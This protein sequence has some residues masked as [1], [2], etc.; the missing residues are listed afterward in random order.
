L[1]SIIK[2]AKQLADANFKGQCSWV[3]AKHIDDE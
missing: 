3:A 2:I 1:E